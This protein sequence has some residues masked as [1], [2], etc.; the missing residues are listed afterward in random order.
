MG[1]PCFNK[2]CWNQ[3][4]EKNQCFQYWDVEKCPDRIKEE[5]VVGE[6]Q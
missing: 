1:K 6:E 4:S 5:K 2:K 3:N